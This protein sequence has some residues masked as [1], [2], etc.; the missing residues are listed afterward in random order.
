ML[1]LLRR[2]CG[3]TDPEYVFILGF[4][5]ECCVLTTATDFFESGI[6]PFVL[7]YYCGS[8]DGDRFHNAGLISM[9]H[10]IG[11]DFLIDDVLKDQE[12][13]RIVVER[14]MK[15]QRENDIRAEIIGTENAFLNKE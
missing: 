15:T 11:P 4:D 6:R 2:E 7:T 14:V 1:G 9:E 5:T 12:D 8:H 13:L 3:G 10:L